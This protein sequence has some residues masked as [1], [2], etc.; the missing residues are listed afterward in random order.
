MR[1]KAME[2][3]KASSDQSKRGI[4]IA[5]FILGEAIILLAVFL[6]MKLQDTGLAMAWFHNP[7]GETAVFGTTLLMLLVT[8]LFPDFLHAFV[9]C[10]KN[11][12]ELTAVQVKKSLL[13]VRLA[14]LTAIIADLLV[15]IYCFVAMI[16]SIT[17]Y[18]DRLGEV[19]P[20]SLAALGGNAIYGLIV[21]LILLPVYARLKAQMISM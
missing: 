4:K 14:M 9:Y 13:S 12:E 1:G 21:T 17:A 11:P 3:V 6:F 2:T 8:G 20:Y 5:L 18:S 15:L 10:V 19:L 16:N 7:A